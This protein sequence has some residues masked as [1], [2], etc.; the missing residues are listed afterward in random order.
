M[1][2]ADS[3]HDIRTA[4]LLVSRAAPGN[5]AYGACTLLVGVLISIW[6]VHPAAWLA[7]IGV[8][9]ALGAL[10]RSRCRRFET[11]FPREPGLWIRQFRLASLGLA[12]SWG[13]LAVLI[14]TT[15]G[16]GP[17]LMLIMLVT[18]GLAG[19]ITSAL[20]ADLRLVVSVLVTMLGMTALATLSLPAPQNLQL[21]VMFAIYLIYCLS[22]SRIQFRQLRAELQAADLLESR[23]RELTVAKHQADAASE[24]KSLFL[25]NMSHEIRTPI[26]GLLGM[27]E[28]TLA[29][30][31]TAEQREYLELARHSGRSLLSLV[32]DLLDFSRI[33]AGRLDLDL[34]DTD[35]RVL[36]SRTVDALVVGNAAVHVPVTWHVDETVPSLCRLD[37]LR[38]RQIL[39]NLL[40]N[41]IKFTRSGSIEVRWRC[42]P[43]EAGGIWLEGEIADTGIGVAPDKL[44]AIFGTFAQADNSFARE[45]GGAG[46]G[47]AITRQLV[48]LMDGTI[49]VKSTPG[50]GSVF[51]FRL[52]VAVSPQQASALSDD[53]ATGP[54]VAP[55]SGLDVLVVEDNLVN[56]RFVEKLL[57]R[58]G[59]RVQV[60]ANGRLGVEASGASDFDLIL[61]DVQ[62][63]EMDGLAATRAI[64]QRER[65]T[66]AHVPIVALTAHASQEDR[67]RCLA[68]GMDD[69]LTKP[70]RVPL[71]DAVL[72][73]LAGAR[74][75]V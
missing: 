68:A 12:I 26:N 43:R 39:V 44:D 18:T 53:D 71:L 17:E 21:S 23:S 37:P 52:A 15:Y 3:T 4:R 16:V 8:Q 28:L 57:E 64:R 1:F 75:T 55:E 63:P 66:G 41:A 5:F 61:M 19:G 2:G 62:M 33:E 46:L 20:S 54:G 40:G 10:R 72:G 11:L 73:Q 59:H 14:T 35:L 29:T 36:V 7:L 65:T 31:L 32:N 48:Q 24:S 67:D 27:T 9:L 42:L 56:A 34:Q 50:Q 25:A 51:S 13:L 6:K 49:A 30:E 38:V 69:Y 45:F 58:R 22:Q 60:A 47:L 70:L 74:A